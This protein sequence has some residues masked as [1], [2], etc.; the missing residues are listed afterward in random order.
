MS[1]SNKSLARQMAAGFV[2][3]FCMVPH[4]INQTKADLWCSAE[5]Y[6]VSKLIDVEKETVKTERRDMTDSIQ[7]F[8]IDTGVSVKEATEKKV[9]G[10]FAK[11]GTSKQ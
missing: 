7:E 3:G 10:M 1:T 4:F 6:L 2:S 8:I 9:S 5:A 11:R